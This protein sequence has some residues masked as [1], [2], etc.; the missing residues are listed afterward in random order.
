[1]IN[2]DINGYRVAGNK[3]LGRLFSQ[4]PKWI[5]YPDRCVFVNVYKLQGMKKEPGD[6][7]LMEVSRRRWQR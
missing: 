6:G 4:L 2:I 1:M 3:F 5:P 7:Q